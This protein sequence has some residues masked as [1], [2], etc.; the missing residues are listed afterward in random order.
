MIKTILTAT[1][2]SLMASTAFAGSLNTD[3]EKPAE[4]KTAFVPTGTGI[5]APAVI[6]GILAAGAII[7]IVA[8]DDDNDSSS[9]TT[10][11]AD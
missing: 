8:S 6:G 11:D 10:V 9:T 1:A 3:F 7:A 4:P 5:G 2:V